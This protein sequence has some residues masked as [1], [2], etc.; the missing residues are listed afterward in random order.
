[1]MD[2]MVSSDGDIPLFSEQGDG[3]ESDTVFGK[4]LVE[5]KN[6]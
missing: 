2:L 6:K 4:I 3:N 1:M 5:F